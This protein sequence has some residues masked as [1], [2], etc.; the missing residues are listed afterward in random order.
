MGY[1]ILAINP[2]STSTKITVYE[3]ETMLYS[4]NIKHSAEEVGKFPSIIS[5]KDYRIQLIRDDLKKNGYDIYDLDAI[6]CRGGLLKALPSGG[7]YEVSDKMVDDLTKAERGEHA[8]NLGGLLARDI[9][10]EIGKKAYTVDPTV[11]DELIDIA[12][13][14][15]L[16]ELPRVSKFHALNQKAIARR[17]AK[18]NG[19][20]YEDVNVVVCHMGGGCSI[21]AHR[22]GKVIDVN[23]A[24][25]GDGPFTPNRTGTLP[26]GDLV[27]LCFSGKYSFA[28][29]YRKIVV[30][31]GTVGYVGSNDFQEIRKKANEGDKACKE[32]LDAY[33]YDV[34]KNI[35]MMAVPLKGEIDAILLTGGI[36][37]GKEIVEGI[38]EYTESIAPVIAYPGEDEMLALTQ[39]VLRVLNGEEAAKVY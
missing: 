27:K 37:Y 5:Q 18:E 23:N 8:S 33:I 15:G 17:Y 22:K 38:R 39:G 29:L 30:N 12:R 25:D 31:G 34:S 16:P 20:K 13:Y 36:A 14:S 26:T 2:G 19:K 35:G 28:E 10:D 7:T 9:A 4:N 6:S 24:L 11:I 3:D 1:K 32:L 21:G